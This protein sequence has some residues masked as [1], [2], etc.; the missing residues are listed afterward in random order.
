MRGKIRAFTLIELLV[1]ISVIA[2][3]IGIT[4]PAL[5]GARETSRRLKCLT[6]LKGIGGGF[7]V[8]F[9]DHK[10]FL[11]R[12][13]PLHGSGGPGG[14]N[15]PSLLDLLADYVDA[16]TPR[17][18]DDGYFIVT[19]PYRCPSDR[20]SEDA[21]LGFEPKWRT[22]GVSY[23]YPPGIFMDFAEGIFVRN[24]AYG[25]TKA[26]ENDR[27][28]PIVTDAGDWHKLRSTGSA[29]NA[30]YYGDLHADWSMD[31]N[32]PGLL[33]PFFKDVVAF[34]GGIAP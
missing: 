14:G 1:S 10:N 11:P 15:D 30:L 7:Q 2:L 21:E 24:P 3:L 6:N 4:I 8:Y 31:I 27:A 16:P 33:G 5:G 23:D 32:D 26:Y 18:G 20:A 13:S 22:D 25:V 9:N 17:K 12:V 19:D 29:R 28:W 34:G